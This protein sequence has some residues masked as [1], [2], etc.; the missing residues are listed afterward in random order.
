MGPVCFSSSNMAPFLILLVASV[1]SVE[2]TP[3]LELYT[4]TDAGGAMINLTDYNHDLS[5]IG[6]DN[7]IQSVCGQGV[8]LLYEDRN[9]NGE[10]ENDW[11]HWTEVFTSGTYTCHNLPST[12]FGKLSSVRYAGSGDLAEDT[13]TLYH[14]YNFD[15]GEALFLKDED[16]LADMNNEPS[17]L[18]ITGCTA[19]TLYQHEYYQGITICAEVHPIGGDLCSAAYDLRDVGF[20]NN[21]LSSIRRGCYAEKTIHLDSQ[22]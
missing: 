7:M 15:G 5:L 3:F 20:P 18:V 10:S 19:W 21:R 1:L 22:V 6:F 13:L 16:D 17:S 9:Y 14:G 4:L 11:E 12:H 2:A 8:W